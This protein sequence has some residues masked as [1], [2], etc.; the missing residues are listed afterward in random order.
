MKFE[1]STVGW[2]IGR[3]QVPHG[4]D[5]WQ[6]WDRTAGV[7]GPQGSGKTLD[8]LTPALLQAPG[9]ALVT[10]TGHGRDAGKY[11]VINNG[12]HIGYVSPEDAVIKVN[13][14]TVVTHDDFVI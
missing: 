3:S 7:I 6:P 9:A 2:R 4:V 12:E 10:L 13:M 1:P 5:L 14:A 8:L 11:V